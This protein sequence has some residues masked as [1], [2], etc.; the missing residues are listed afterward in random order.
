M[1][2]CASEDMSRQS[3]RK[4]R[5]NILS[6]IEA[7]QIKQKHREENQMGDSY[8]IK[9]GQKEKKCRRESN[10]PKGKLLGIV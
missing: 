6:L 10:P 8:V 5:K 4:S 9:K 3:N 7:V 1:P 2:D